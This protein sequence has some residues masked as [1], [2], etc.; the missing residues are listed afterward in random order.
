MRAL[1][2]ATK[3]SENITK[4]EES[5]Q[6]RVVVVEAHRKKFNILKKF[7]LKRLL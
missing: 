3:F 1:T 2:L 6:N 7:V 4:D 5:Y